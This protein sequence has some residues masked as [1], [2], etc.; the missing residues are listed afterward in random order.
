LKNQIELLSPARNLDCGK[1]AI[2]HGADAVYI[3]AP[4]FSARADASNPV[5]DIEKL[6]Q[7]AHLYKAKVYVALNTILFD[8]EIENAVRLIYKLYEVGIDALII[9]DMGLLQCNLPPIKLFASTQTH[10][11]TPEKISFLEKVGFSR[12]ILAREL[13]LK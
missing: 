9:Q 2:L 11:N 6:T 4:S 8:N 10:N 7:Y 1:A 5:A 3:G 13:T 12:V